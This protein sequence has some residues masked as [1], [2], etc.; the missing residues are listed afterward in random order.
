MGLFLGL[1]HVVVC[2]LLVLVVLMQSSKGGVAS[3]L[4]GGLSSSSVLGGRSATTFLTK[5][6]AV[7]A[8]TFM[9]SC[10]VQSITYRSTSEP[11]SA[12]ERVLKE[13]G[14]P[15]AQVPFSEMPSFEESGPAA[16]SEGQPAA[17]TEQP[18]VK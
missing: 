10:L 2:A 8:T 9:L 5:A 6:T 3:S 4:G 7:L 11:T 1:I 16:A 13:G 17:Q 18:A 14:V 15:G 12:T